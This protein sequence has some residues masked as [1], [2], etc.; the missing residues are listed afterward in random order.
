M[1]LIC[2]PVCVYILQVTLSTVNSRPSISRVL[3]SSSSP[4]ASSS[5]PLN[6]ATVDS[7][8]DTV[9]TTHTTYCV[10]SH[11]HK[12]TQNKWK[13]HLN[14][15]LLLQVLARVDPPSILSI[16][17][18]KANSTAPTAPPREALQ[19]RRRGHI[20]MNRYIKSDQIS[21]FRFSETSLTTLTNIHLTYRKI[22]I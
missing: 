21:D 14:V 6:K 13:H 20:P 9:R 4:S 12:H 19:H 17:R 8:R 11:Q 10:H 3:A 18:V 15:T 22:G 5:T 16:S 2:V 1:W 7:H